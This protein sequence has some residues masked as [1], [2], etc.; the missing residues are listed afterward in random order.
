MRAPPGRT[1]RPL[2]IL[3]DPDGSLLAFGADGIDI[4]AV[5]DGMDDRGWHL[6]R[7]RNPDAL[8][9]M[10]TPNHAGAAEEF[11]ADLRDAVASHGASRGARARYS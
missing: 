10:V 3:G 6:D 7:Q 11:L 8:H 1:I 2:R 4:T 9:M 5:A